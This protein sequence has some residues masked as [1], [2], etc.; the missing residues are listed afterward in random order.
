LIPKAHRAESIPLQPHAL[1]DTAMAKRGVKVRDLAR[2][3]GVTTR[4]VIDRCRAEGYHVQ[5]GITKLSPDLERAVRA[6]FG[7]GVS[8]PGH[9]TAERSEEPDRSDSS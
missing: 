8:S 5:N 9:T 2:E 4:R 6:W 1:Y 7:A 3:L